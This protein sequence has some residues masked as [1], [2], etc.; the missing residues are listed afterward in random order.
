MS[1]PGVRWIF[2]A[3]KFFFSIGEAAFVRR[4]SH[5][6][7]GQ[8]DSNKSRTKMTESYEFALQNFTVPYVFPIAKMATLS[9]L[10]FSPNL[11]IL[12]VGARGFET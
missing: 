12:L 10:I 9:R 2:Y 1:L 4:P 6:V 8:F 7:L 3:S 5:W 11:L